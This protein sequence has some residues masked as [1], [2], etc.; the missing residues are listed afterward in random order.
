MTRFQKHFLLITVALGVGLISWF[1]IEHTHIED[2]QLVG[3]FLAVWIV[4]TIELI[5]ILLL[6]RGE[7]RQPN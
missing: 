5:V 4:F 1:L 6:E 3:G 2:K 7:T